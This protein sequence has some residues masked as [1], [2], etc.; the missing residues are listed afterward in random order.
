MSELTLHLVG[1]EAMTHFGERIAEVTK[2][3]GVIFWKVIWGQVK[4]RFR[5]ASS[6]ALGTKVRSRARPSP[7]LNPMK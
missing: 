5:G 7:S 3:V 6:V 2:G 1:E 4:P